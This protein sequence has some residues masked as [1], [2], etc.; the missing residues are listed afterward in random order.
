MSGSV[1]RDGRLRCNHDRDSHTHWPRLYPCNKLAVVMYQPKGWLGPM[2]YCDKHA[3]IFLH[4]ND[5]VLRSPQG[6]FVKDGEGHRFQIIPYM[7][8]IVHRL[9][10]TW[11]ALFNVLH[12]MMN[13]ILNE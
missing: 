13:T 3:E 11:G 7:K 1:T 5:I 9:S 10:K 8:I 2:Y 6:F 4:Q 12:G